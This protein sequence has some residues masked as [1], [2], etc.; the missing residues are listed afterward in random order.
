MD[1]CYIIYTHKA[2]IKEK[3]EKNEM[4]KENSEYIKNHKTKENKKPQIICW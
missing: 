2:K 4:R 3:Q 1:S